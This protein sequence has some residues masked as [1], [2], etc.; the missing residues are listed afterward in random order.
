[1]GITAGSREAPEKRPVTRKDNT[2]NTNNNN[3]SLK[4]PADFLVGS[5]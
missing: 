1:V 2:N 5:P 4:A 3:K